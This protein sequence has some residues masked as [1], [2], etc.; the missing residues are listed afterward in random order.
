MNHLYAHGTM[1]SAGDEFNLYPMYYCRKCGN[2]HASF[3]KE[4]D[5]LRGGW[6][7]TSNPAAPKVGTQGPITLLDPDPL[8][9]AMPEHYETVLRDEFAKIA[10]AGLLGN[11]SVL[12]DS[13]AIADLAYHIADEMMAMRARSQS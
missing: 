9:P 2:S 7:I 1:T 8:T 3:L 12:L 6:P 10:L 13:A 11:E 5:G 4:C